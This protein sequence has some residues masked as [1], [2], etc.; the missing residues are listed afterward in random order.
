MVSILI[1]KVFEEFVATFEEAPANKV[2]KTWIKAGTY[3]AG[4]RR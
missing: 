2:N 3:D 4:K 1:L